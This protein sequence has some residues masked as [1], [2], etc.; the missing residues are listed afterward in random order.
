MSVTE[1]VWLSDQEQQAW[2]G[3]LRMHA[4]LMLALNRGLQNEAGLSLSDFG[5]LVILSEH[6]S[7]RMRVLEL[8]R[9]LQ[10][11]KSRVSHQ[12]RRMTDR[13]LIQ[14]AG[15]PDDKRG[16]FVELTEA[17]L[18]AIETAAPTHVR[19]VRANL[20]DALTP[21]DVAAL[22]RIS[23]AAIAVIEAD[24]DEECAET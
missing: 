2:R 13:G 19:S 14:R 10:W 20:F 1:T 15:C 23:D 7:R 21:E 11:E 16:A 6:P 12:L 17:G 24:C 9:A 22:A 4:L 3:L 18:A 5:V 8:A